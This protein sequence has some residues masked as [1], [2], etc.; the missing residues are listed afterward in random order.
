MQ[1]TELIEIINKN[2]F[3]ELIIFIF[4]VS[5]PYI[6]QKKYKFIEEN[7]LIK[8]SLQVTFW[9]NVILYSIFNIVLI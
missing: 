3:I 6:L 5:T 1:S 4:L 8:V 7:F 9:S 2:A